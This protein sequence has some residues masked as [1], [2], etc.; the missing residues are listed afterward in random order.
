MHFLN[1]IDTALF[2]FLNGLHHPVSDFLFFWISNKYIWIPLYTYLAW[3]LFTRERKDFF[4]LLISVALAITISDQLAS[5]VLKNL[6]MRPR[7]CHEAS[8]SGLVHTVYGHCGGLY[9]FVSSHASNAFALCAFMLTLM[10]GARW[11]FRYYLVFWACLH[12]YSR[13][14]LGVHYPG[15]IIGGA[16]VGLSSGYVCAFAYIKYKELRHSAD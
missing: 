11:K 16:L 8:L 5:T 4:V 7:P 6:V 3:Y 14:Y 10:K 1:D 15:D 9:G 2:L 12:S 13:I